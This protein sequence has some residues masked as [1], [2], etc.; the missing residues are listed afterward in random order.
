MS[1]TTVRKY[2]RSPNEVQKHKRDGIKVS[3]Y[4]RVGH[5]VRAHRRYLSELPDL[6][7]LLTTG[8]P[9]KHDVTIQFTPN[10]RKLIYG[11]VGILAGAA[12]LA[13]LLA[14]R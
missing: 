3:A 12:V 9:I 13:V 2:F 11:S 1:Y 10:D 14:K 5:N 6:N 4:V 7:T 8:V